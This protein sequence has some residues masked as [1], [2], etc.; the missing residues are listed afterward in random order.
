V[1]GTEEIALV[2]RG[3]DAFIAGD[4]EWLND[5]MHENVV[6]HATG[7]GPLS[8]DHHGREE[9]LAV[10]AKAVELAVPEFDIHDVAAGDDHVV[11]VLNVT[12]RRPAGQ[13]F[14]SRAVQVFHISDERVLESWFL[15]EDQAG[16]DAFLGA[17]A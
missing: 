12:W 11:S 3:Y 8:G 4:M 13:T 14:S 17:G 15:A 6:W 7:N 5:H 16:L 9:V 1:A 2:R 10:L